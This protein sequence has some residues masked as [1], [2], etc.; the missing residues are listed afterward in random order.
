M[1][2][3]DIFKR[4]A[5]KLYYSVYQFLMDGSPINVFGDNESYVTEGYNGNPDVYSI[6]NRIADNACRP[7]LKLCY[8]DKDEIIK[9]DTHP[10][11]DLLYQ[12]NDYMTYKEFLRGWYV[13]KFSIGNSY[14]YRL[15]LESGNNVGKPV[16]LHITPSAFME[17]ESGGWMNPVKGYK[18][19]LGDQQTLFN[20][21][22]IWHSKFFNPDFQ[23]SYHLYGLSPIEVAAKIINAQNAGYNATG[24]A[25]ENGGVPFVM[26]GKDSKD[27]WTEEQQK[28]IVKKFKENHGGSDNAGK[29]MFLSN[30]VELHQVGLSP[31]DLNIIESTKDGRKILCN[32]LGGVPAGLLND[33]QADTY[34]NMKERGKALFRNV[35]IPN[36]Q[37]FAD[38]LSRFI[39]PYYKQ[40]DS[41]DYYFEFDYTGIEELQEDLKEKV[42]ALVNAYGLTLR[43][44]LEIAGLPADNE[45]KELDKIYIPIGLTTVG[46]DEIPQDDVDK[47]YSDN[48]INDYKK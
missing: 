6:I 21:D 1:K 32:V 44:K 30:P 41:K 7:E 25:F 22:E 15:C 36:N 5:N 3:V 43:Q 34:N 28:R 46:E 27:H 14:V 29:P 12:P 26:T 2:L 47:Y 16:E 8:K 17:I 38:G 39:L 45:D 18:L 42:D 23:Q 37:D 13:Y 33:Q 9:L 24:K 20:P 19:L 11:L 31:V 40:K 10:A 48:N 35:I 4:K